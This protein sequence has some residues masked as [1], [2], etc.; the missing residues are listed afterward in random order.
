MNSCLHVLCKTVCAG[1]V[2]GSLRLGQGFAWH[3]AASLSGVGADV[4]GMRANQ[5]NEVSQA[6]IR[7]L[8]F[9][10]VL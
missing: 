6:R 5:G 10:L 1:V 2:L 9:S 3:S 7:I 4:A 8:L